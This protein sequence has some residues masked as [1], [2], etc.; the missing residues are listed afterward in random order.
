VLF[1]QTEERG[2]IHITLTITENNKSTGAARFDLYRGASGTALA[3]VDGRDYDVGDD[4]Q[5]EWL[6][7][8][9]QTQATEFKQR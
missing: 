4:K 6:L 3:V 9:L 5:R 2:R 1:G 8:N 7:A